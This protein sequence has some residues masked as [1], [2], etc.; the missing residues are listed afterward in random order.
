MDRSEQLRAL[1]STLPERERRV[2]VLRIDGLTF[3]Q[4]GVELE[5]H[6]TAAQRVL[7]RAIWRLQQRT[8]R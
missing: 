8:T 1:L 7:R 6:W 2:V 3:R 5:I 4:I